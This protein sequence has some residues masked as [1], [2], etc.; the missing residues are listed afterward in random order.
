MILHFKTSG[1]GQP[2]IILHGLLGMLDNWLSVAKE[3]EK[4]FTV[5]LIDQRNHG[6]SPHTQE[7]SYALMAEDLSEFYV[8]QG[9]STAHILGHSMGGKTAMQFALAYPEKVQ[10]LTVA[11]MGVRSYES[12]HDEIF[13]ALFSIDLPKIHYRADAEK[14][15]LDKIDDFTV[16]QFLLKSLAR[17][18]DGSYF[19][20]FN[21]EALYRNYESEIQAAVQ[22][23]KIFTGKT[24]FIRGERSNYVKNEDWDE[25]QSLFPNATL[26]TIKDA[27]HWVH[28]DKPKEFIATVISFLQSE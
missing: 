13:D 6:R 5:Y 21:L 4:Y 16:R 15:L 8:Q 17:K 23:N 19:W 24:L 9:L 28:A 7:H 26:F 2:L 1:A 14:I 22:S 11:D 18:T 25:I 20:R 10:R 27:G 3:L 12:G